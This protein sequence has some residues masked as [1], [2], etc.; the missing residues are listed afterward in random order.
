ML[1]KSTAS[2]NL[3][4]TTKKTMVVFKSKPA[5]VLAVLFKKDQEKTT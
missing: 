1:K 3:Y 2:D 4:V 5:G